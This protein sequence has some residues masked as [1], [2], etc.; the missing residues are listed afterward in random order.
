MWELHGCMWIRSVSSSGKF[1][2]VVAI[3]TNQTIY[4]YKASLLHQG[5]TISANGSVKIF[6]NARGNDT[7]KPI[8]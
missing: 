7:G 6:R 2:D 1:I 3:K 4:E 8:V 5:R